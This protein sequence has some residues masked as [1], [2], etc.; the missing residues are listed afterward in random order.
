MCTR[1][2]QVADQEGMID[3]LRDQVHS[4]QGEIC[5]LSKENAK[6]LQR[7]M[8]VSSACWLSSLD[9]FGAIWPQCRMAIGVD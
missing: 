4:L 7:M 5:S 8:Q 9:M 3:M 6:L 2:L 1:L